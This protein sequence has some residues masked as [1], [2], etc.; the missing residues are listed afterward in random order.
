MSSLTLVEKGTLE[1]VPQ[2]PSFRIFGSMNPATDVGKKN[3]PMCAGASLKCGFLPLPL[4]GET[5]IDRHSGTVH[6]TCYCGTPV[7]HPGH[8]RILWSSQKTSMQQSASGWIESLTPFQ[9]ADPCSSTYFHFRCYP[10]GLW[11]ALWEGCWVLL[12]FNPTLRHHPLLP[13]HTILVVRLVLSL[14]PLVHP[15]VFTLMPDEVLPFVNWPTEITQLLNEQPTHHLFQLLKALFPDNM[16]AMKGL[17]VSLNKSINVFLRTWLTVYT[18]VI[19]CTI[20][21]E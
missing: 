13:T 2:H 16:H 18:I 20:Y 3:L 5:S 14:L 7:C 11:R 6:Q 1:P 8:C 10:F 4:R 15:V 17:G 12:L 21:S 19:Y 9:Y